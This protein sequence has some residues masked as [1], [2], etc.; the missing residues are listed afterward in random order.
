MELVN[1]FL[2]SLH[3][4]CL[5]IGNF[6]SQVSRIILN[7]IQGDEKGPFSMTVTAELLQH[8]V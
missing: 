6:T 3:M 8:A 2:A 7:Q 4:D 5:V 1:N